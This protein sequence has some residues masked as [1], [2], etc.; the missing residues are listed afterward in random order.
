MDYKTE[1]MK[2]AKLIKAEETGI[3]YT[4]KNSKDHN[5]KYKADTI[6]VYDNPNQLKRFTAVITGREWDEPG[7]T[8]KS[9][10]RFDMNGKT[11][12]ATGK[13]DQKLGK[14]VAWKSIPAAVQKK[15]LNQLSGKW[16]E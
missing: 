9:L 13:E 10:I 1:L 8:D 15:V 16:E 2:I 14:P 3:E 5:F 7:S 12:F 4:E 6:R 11:V